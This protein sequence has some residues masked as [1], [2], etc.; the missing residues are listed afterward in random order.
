[1][2]APAFCLGHIPATAQGDG[3]KAEQMDEA[4]ICSQVADTVGICDAEC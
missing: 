3:G 1:M 4:G 2:A